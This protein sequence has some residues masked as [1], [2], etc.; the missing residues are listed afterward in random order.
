MRFIAYDAF[1]E[2]FSQC[3]RKEYYI[4]K[5]STTKRFKT[6]KHI[7][8]IKYS[9]GNRFWIRKGSFFIK[10]NDSHCY[11]NSFLY[12]STNPFQIALQLKMR[13]LESRSHILLTP[14]RNSSMDSKKHALALQKYY[15]LAL[16][17][18]SIRHRYQS[19][20]KNIH[21]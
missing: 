8:T 10:A 16:T 7:I 5:K 13:C 18:I 2:L 19:I 20:I 12:V 14:H 3:L 21:M 1:V 17:E 15:G 11:R 4:G 6:I 9:E